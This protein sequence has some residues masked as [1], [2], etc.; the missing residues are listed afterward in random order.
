MDK[1]KSEGNIA[2]GQIGFSGKYG[3]GGAGKCSKTSVKFQEKGKRGCKN[4]RKGL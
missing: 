4:L 2:D 1:K 3:G